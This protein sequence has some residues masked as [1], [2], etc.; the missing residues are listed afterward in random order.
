M[1]QRGFSWENLDLFIPDL[2]LNLGGKPGVGT[3]VGLALT[4][5]FFGSLFATSFLIIADFFNTK[6]PILSQNVIPTDFPPF[7]SLKEDRLYPIMVFRFQATTIVSKSELARFMT[8]NLV[9]AD[10]KTDPASGK[11]TTSFQTL[12]FAPCSELS[13]Q[14]KL[15][16]LE[17]STPGTKEF[18]LSEGFCVDVEEKDFTLGQKT[19]G[20][21]FAQQV[22]W[23]LL[24]CSLS[25]GCATKEE[26][27]QVSFSFF[28]PKP[29]VDLTSKDNPVQFMVY[30]EELFYLSTGIS[31][32]QTL[33]LEKTAIVDEAGMLQGSNFASSFTSIQNTRYNAAA[34][35]PT[36]TTCT[37]QQISG[38]LCRHYWQQTLLTGNS[39][40]IIK[41]QY[42]GMVETVS[43]LGG[44]LDLLFLVFYFPYTI[45]NNMVLKEKIVELVF[46]V[47]KP[48]KNRPAKK[49]GAKNQIVQSSAEEQT[50]EKEQEKY[51]H[52]LKEADNVFD[53][54]KLSKEVNR[55]IQILKDSKA[56]G[57]KDYD[58][59]PDKGG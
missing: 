38:G 48:V 5:V 2:R 58:R 59:Q 4:L 45:Y 39:K 25:S 9:K 27:N 50:Y 36:Q 54:V 8:V 29:I 57:L 33:N 32:Q 49:Q 46:G 41:R 12:K 1:R 19:P 37:L 17:V 56:H 31:G 53:L 20:E 35:D 13:A 10:V 44:M 26:V 15:K 40:R 11:A 24:P 30:P 3:K 6:K 21:T 14:G 34:R 23:R 47:K 7:I 18:L 55:I 52:L 42:K 28:M 43:E 16:T 51:G 22:M